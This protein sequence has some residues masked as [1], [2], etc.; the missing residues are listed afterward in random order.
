VPRSCRLFSLIV[1]TGERFG[2]AWAGS[3]GAGAS[4]VSVAI[5]KPW[6]SSEEDLQLANHH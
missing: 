4:S 1:S 2:A 3:V 5:A 6:E